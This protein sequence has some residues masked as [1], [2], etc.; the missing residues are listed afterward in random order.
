MRTIGNLLLALLNATLLLF[1][2][3]VVLGLVL[4]DRTRTIAADVA[5]DVTQSA[6]ASTGLDP[7]DTL[8]E[9]RVV[10]TEMIDLRTAIEERRSDLGERTQALSARLDTLESMLND[11]SERKEE[12]ADAA[13]D[14]ASI[15]AGN[16][17]ERMRGCT[18]PGAGT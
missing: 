18:P 10:S 7:A 3:A 13:I 4:I 17:L 11:L 2:V 14:K 6:I 1:I 15:V 5:A 8:A 9:L 12:L 16:A